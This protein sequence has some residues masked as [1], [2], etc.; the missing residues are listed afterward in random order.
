M[1]E[2]KGSLPQ[3]S[4]TILDHADKQHTVDGGQF[5][6]QRGGHGAFQVDDV[7]GHL[8]IVLKAWISTLWR[9]FGITAVLT[10]FQ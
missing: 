7:I 5:L 8:T 9:R 4:V 2:T 1:I 3:I 6:F 10:Y